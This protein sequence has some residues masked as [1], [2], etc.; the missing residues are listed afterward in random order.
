MDNVVIDINTTINAPIITVDDVIYNIEIVSE[1]TILSSEIDVSTTQ[2]NNTIEASTEIRDVVIDVKRGDDGVQ[3]IQGVQGERGIQGEIG[4]QGIQGIQGVQGTQGEQGVQGMQ[5]IQGDKGDQGIQGDAGATGASGINFRGIWDSQIDYINLDAVYYDGSSWF[6]SGDPAPGDVPEIGSTFWFPLAIRG[7]TGV[8]GIEGAQGIQGIQGLQGVKGDDGVQ[9]V[10]G[11]QGIQGVAGTDGVTQDISG[12]ADLLSPIFT[13]EPL[14]PTAAPGTNTN[15]LA[16]TAFIKNAIETKVDARASRFELSVDIILP[17]SVTGS[18]SIVDFN[19]SVF[20]IDTSLFINNG[21]GVVTCTRSGIYL[22]TTCIVLESPLATA[23]TKSEL[24]I[25]KNEDTIICATTDDTPIALGN[26]ARSLSTSTIINLT[27]NDTLA[28]I[29]NLYGSTA[30][31]RAVRLPALFGT[32]LTQVS[33][34]S[35]QKLEI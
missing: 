23:I 20:N 32:T 18:V 12:K 22:V 34:I 7:E 6:A 25:I 11:I 24:G 5:G 19:G 3:G 13:G 30:N 28:T 14:A 27:A 17:I 4:I 10:Q 31:G 26:N 8:Q 1:S 29:V 33:N 21:S 35:I 2:I 16:T 15:Q 9:G